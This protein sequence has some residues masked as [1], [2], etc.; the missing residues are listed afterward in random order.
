MDFLMFFISFISALRVFFLCFIF[1]SLIIIGLRVD[2][3][4]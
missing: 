1:K 2:L 4:N 3:V